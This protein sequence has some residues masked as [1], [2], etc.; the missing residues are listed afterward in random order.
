MRYKI[1]IEERYQTHQ[2]KFGQ[3]HFAWREVC[4]IWATEVQDGLI[5]NHTDKIKPGM[6]VIGN[7][8]IM[9]IGKVAD[10]IEGGKKS[11]LLTFSSVRGD[12]A[13]TRSAP[14]QTGLPDPQD[15]HGKGKG[16]GKFL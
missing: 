7:S 2:D 5:I 3:P 8:R 1:L 11:L 10:Y 15:E 13:R 6:Q 16:Q 4:E 9:I 14:G 12:Y